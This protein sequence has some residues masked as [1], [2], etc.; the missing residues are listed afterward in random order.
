MPPDPKSDALIRSLASDDPAARAR[1]ATEI[2]D[3]GRAVAMAATAPWLADSDIANLLVRNDTGAPLATVGIA[4][5]P[6]SFNQIR[7]ANGTPRLADVPPDQDALEFELHFAG[8][9]QLDILTAR[10]TA[11]GAAIAR[12]LEKFGE[13]IQQVEFLVQNVDRAAEILRTRF[14]IESIYPATRNGA[15]GTRVN[16]FLVPAPGGQKV[17]IELVEIKR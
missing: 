7:T 12:Y 6:E 10:D 16:F 17:L 8:G 15:D 11:A 9:I 3:L 5:R 14:A 2:F 1:A 13:G 4:V